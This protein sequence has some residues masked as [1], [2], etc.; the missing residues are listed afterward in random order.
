MANLLMEKQNVFF[1]D[2]KDA[3]GYEA[4]REE[5]VNAGDFGPLV[6]AQ[7]VIDFRDRFRARGV[8]TAAAAEAREA[9]AGTR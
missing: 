4:W 9:R 3:G 1:H 2:Y 6:Y 7:Q 8:V 5:H